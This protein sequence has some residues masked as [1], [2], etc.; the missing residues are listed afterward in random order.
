MTATTYRALAQN[1]GFRTLFTVQAGIMASSSTSALALGVVVFDQTRSPLLTALAMFGGPL[2][3]FAVSF[4]F[5]AF[6]DR[7]PPRTGVGLTAA[8]LLVTDL[9]QAVPNLPW[10][11]RFVLLAIPWC[12]N[13]ATSGSKWLVLR[14]VVGSDDYLFGRATLNIAVSVTQI[15][16]YGVG[17]TLLQFL[18]PQALFLVAAGI[19]A[20][21][22][23]LTFTRIPPVDAPASH[24]PAEPHR[25]AHVVARTREVNGALLRS[26]TTRPV[27][28]SLWIPNGLVVGCEALFVPLAGTHSGYLYMAGAA[29]MLAGDV[30]VGRWVP[31]A[32]RDRLIGPLRMLIATP[33]LVFFL[34]PPLAVAGV[35]IAA[36]SVGYAA[37]LPLQD[38]LIR[39]T[40]PETRGQTLGLHTTGMLVSQ[41]AAAALAGTVAS[42]VT[43]AVT[44]GILGG[45]SLAV[46]VALTRGLRRSAPRSERTTAP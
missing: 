33:Y 32:R 40:D 16:G 29:G 14:H 5:L 7:I 44:I 20:C 31:T 23:I 28:L 1:P 19:D 18:T 10:P 25:S 38:R 4:L 6:S 42:V 12:V 41:G 2:I 35:A 34:H 46:T 21:V 24:A 15:A 13:S 27:Y 45:L 30:L 9:A 17:G 26:R 39:A 22:L 43:P 8:A 11:V 37:S 36:A 3:A